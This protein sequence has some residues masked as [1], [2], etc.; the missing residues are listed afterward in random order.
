MGGH[1]TS[2]N[3]NASF[4]PQLRGQLARHLMKQYLC[5]AK[6]DASIVRPI[7]RSNTQGK[8][9]VI[10]QTLLHLCLV[11]FMAS[12]PDHAVPELSDLIL[13]REWCW[14]V[15]SRWLLHSSSSSYSSSLP[16]PH[17]AP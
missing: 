17:R 7:T 6:E 8:G 2:G 5:W 15:C 11:K 13:W 4:G 3:A 1:R 12:G 9:G 10:K 16:I 14:C